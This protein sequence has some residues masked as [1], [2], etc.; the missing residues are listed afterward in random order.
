MLRWQT[1][2]Q[3]YRGNMTIVHNAGKI[4]KNADGLS[5]WALANS[6]DN[7]YY[8]P[9]EEEAQIPIKGINMTDIGTEFLEGGIESYSQYK[10][11][12]ILTILFDKY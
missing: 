6:P 12:H 2:I 7:P 8:V 11:C 4:H 5:R 3:E 1:A 10:N 9:L